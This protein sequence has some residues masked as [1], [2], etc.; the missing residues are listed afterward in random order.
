MTGLLKAQV[1]EPAPRP[2]TQNVC[3]LRNPV[4]TKFQLT[5]TQGFGSTATLLVCGPSSEASG[6]MYEQR[7]WMTT[8]LGLNP[9][10][11]THCLASD[12][13]PLCAPASHPCVQPRSSYSYCADRVKPRVYRVQHGLSRLGQSSVAAALPLSPSPVPGQLTHCSGQWPSHWY[14]SKTLQRSGSSF[15]VPKGSGFRN[16]EVCESSKEI[17]TRFSNLGWSYEPPKVKSCS[18]TEI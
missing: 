3:G 1:P 16:T 14:C 5:L 18:L 17:I 8:D 4:V 2:Y 10:P 13:E 7:F 15:R 9:V 11:A 12:N 6:S